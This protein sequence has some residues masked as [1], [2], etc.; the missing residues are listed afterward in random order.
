MAAKK[1]IGSV[2]TTPIQPEGN[3]KQPGQLEG[4]QLQSMNQM[5]ASIAA[6]EQ[7]VRGLDASLSKIE[8]KV[9]KI[10]EKVSAIDKKIY[11]ATI[12]VGLLILVGGFIVHKAVDFGLEMAK[13][14][15]S[16][17]N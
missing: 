14:A 1:G 15:I 4:W 10:D 8:A 17:Q 6:L 9:D 5:T 2:A 3:P 13:E 12:I 11:A 7:S 16:A